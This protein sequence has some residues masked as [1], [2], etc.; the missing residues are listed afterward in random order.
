MLYDVPI[1]MNRYPALT[2]YINSM[3]AGCRAWLHAGELEKV[4]IVMLSEQGRTLETLVIETKWAMA[5]ATAPP[6]TSSGDYGAD[7]GGATLSNSTLSN[8]ILEERTQGL[9]LLKIEEVFRAALVALVAAPRPDKSKPTRE[10]H[11]FRFLAH[12]T[13]SVATSATAVA[14]ASV[15]NSWVLADPFWFN[16]NDDANGSEVK[17]HKELLPIKSVRSNDFPFTLQVYLEAPIM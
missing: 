17:E 5:N 12:T 2:E 16:D 7:S 8:S 10:P 9:P 6:R 14:V 3:L 4:C 13:E 11:S 15:E 1:H